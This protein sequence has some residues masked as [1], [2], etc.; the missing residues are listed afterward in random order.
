MHDVALIREYVPA[1]QA[2]GED[3]RLAHWY[4]LGHVAHEEAPGTSAYVP[5]AHGLKHEQ[6]E[7]RGKKFGEIKMAKVGNE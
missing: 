1:A 5:S 3:P 4:P 7:I 6:K 2:I